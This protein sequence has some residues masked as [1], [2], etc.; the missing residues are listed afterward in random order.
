[1]TMTRSTVTMKR[2]ETRE[3]IPI[4]ETEPARGLRWPAAGQGGCSSSPPPVAARESLWLQ[5]IHQGYTIAEIAHREGLSR[6]RI[7]TGIGRAREREVLSRKRNS[8]ERENVPVR[9]DEP[10]AGSGDAERDEAR[11][12]PRLVPLFPIG[13]FTPQSTCPHHGPIRP[14][15]VFC[16][17]V[18]SQSGMDEHPALKRDPLTDPR[19]ENKEAARQLVNRCRE[20]RKERRR[21]LH[22]NRQA[23][24]THEST[25]T[26]LEGVL[27]YLRANR[28][29]H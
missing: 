24:L 17:M 18:C 28:P 15:S 6:R 4:T 22:T 20:T 23:A 9:D 2:T 14:G 8:C 19:P 13:A 16:C 1:M 11:R 3:Q 5:E 27:A 25:A 10:V 21:R 7:T 26:S 12:P 29:R